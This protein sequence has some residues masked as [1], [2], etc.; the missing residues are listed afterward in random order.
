MREKKES[1]KDDIELVKRKLKVMKLMGERNPMKE[2]EL[3]K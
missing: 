1:T 3:G 2:R